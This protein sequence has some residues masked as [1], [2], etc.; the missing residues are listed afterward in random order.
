[1]DRRHGGFIETTTGRAFYP[2]DPRPEDIDIIDIA[3]AL[4]R[5]CRFAGHGAYPWSVAA[6]SLQV[7]DLVP[8]EFKPWAL[9]HDA[10]EAYL[11]DIPRPLKNCAGMGFYRMAEDDLMACICTR[12]GLP[13]T[14]PQVVKDADK[15]ILWYEARDLFGEPMA[16]WWDKWI[17]FAEMFP[18]KGVVIEPL[19]PEIAKKR[20]LAEFY[21]LFA[22]E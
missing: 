15:A 7:M 19:A 20:F 22:L 1:M 2:L 11:V 12:F 4:S 21:R 18:S 13:L 17:P 6:H 10:S 3:T 9:L 16:E 14:C 8:E 5:Q